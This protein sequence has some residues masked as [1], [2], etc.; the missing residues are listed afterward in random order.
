MRFLAGRGFAGDVVR[1]VLAAALS[2]DDDEGL[3]DGDMAP[4]RS[5]ADD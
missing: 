3:V 1:R 4:G 2:S 5:G